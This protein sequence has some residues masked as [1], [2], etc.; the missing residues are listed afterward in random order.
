MSESRSHLH[1]QAAWW[2]ILGKIGAWIHDF[3]APKPAVPQF[4]RLVKTTTAG[5]SGVGTVELKFYVRP[6]Y[7][8]RMNGQRFPV[9]V[10]FHGGGFTMGTATDDGRWAAVVLEEVQAVFVS[11]EYRLAPEHPFPTAVED[12]LE[13]LLYLAN[14]AEGF[15]LDAMKMI[16]TGFSAGGNMTFTV[17]LKLQAYLESLS[18]NNMSLDAPKLTPNN[19]PGIIGIVSW[20]PILDYGIPREDKRA[21]SVRPDK[22]LPPFLT[23]LFDE[24]YLPDS[25]DRDSPFLSPALAPDEML[26]KGLPSKIAVFVCEWDMLL[27]EGRLFAKRLKDLGKSVDCTMIEEVRHGFDKMPSL[28]VDPKVKLHYLEACRIINDILIEK[29]ESVVPDESAPS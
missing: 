5:T 27:D 13:A 19:I 8:E 25:D 10:N 2:R 20:Y 26:V 15:G 18:S 28:K 11:V 3:P 6:D 21:A 14:N 23:D 29:P 24:A 16:L 22:C 7:A 12:G 1:L 4:T 17:P 9:V